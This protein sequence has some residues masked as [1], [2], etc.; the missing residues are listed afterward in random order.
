M[1]NTTSTS[2]IF[3]Y[4]KLINKKKA[5]GKKNNKLKKQIKTV[6][7]YVSSGIIGP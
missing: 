5:S 3:Q 6:D 4:I 7:L 2:K 1:I